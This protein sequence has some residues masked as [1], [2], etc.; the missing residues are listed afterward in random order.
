LVRR[1]DPTSFE[2][3]DEEAPKFSKVVSENWEQ[4]NGF[5]P[6]TTSEEVDYLFDEGKYLEEARA[7]IDATYSTHYS[8][9]IQPTE[10]LISKGHGTGFCVGNIIKYAGRYGKKGGYNRADLK[11]I[12]HYAIIQLYVHDRDGLGE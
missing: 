9:D 8:G 3:T 10:F 11:K 5:V 12:I 6:P 2:V 1:I 4:F 7:H